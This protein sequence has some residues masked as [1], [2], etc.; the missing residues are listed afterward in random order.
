MPQPG[1]LA[2]ARTAGRAYAEAG[3]CARLDHGLTHRGHVWTICVTIVTTRSRRVVTGKG[4]KAAR[5]P[6]QF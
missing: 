5:A 2:K 4:E 3:G 1:P 6:G